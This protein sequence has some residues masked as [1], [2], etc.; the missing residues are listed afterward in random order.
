MSDMS[1]SERV[2]IVCH[3]NGDNSVNTVYDYRKFFD[4]FDVVYGTMNE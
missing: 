1:G 3:T 2:S 4:I